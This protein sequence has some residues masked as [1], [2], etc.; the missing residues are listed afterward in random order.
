MQRNVGSE[1]GEEA[2][3]PCQMARISSHL[4]S[5]WGCPSSSA[6]SCAAS[7]RQKSGR[8]W[9]ALFFSPEIFLISRLFPSFDSPLGISTSHSKSSWII[10]VMSAASSGGRGWP[11]E[12]HVRTC[13]AKALVCV[14][15]YRAAPF[16]VAGFLFCLCIYQTLYLR[17][18]L[19]ELRVPAWAPW[20]PFCDKIFHIIGIYPLF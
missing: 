4:I 14:V 5:D 18:H 19:E 9:G 13:H 3:V 10:P 15:V 2:A 20:D 11:R 6:R 12:R 7:E 17:K 1:D 8:V 16:E